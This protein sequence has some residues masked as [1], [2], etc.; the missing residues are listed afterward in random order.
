M[1]KQTLIAFWKYDS[2]PFLL[3]GEVEEVKTRGLVSVKKYGSLFRPTI[4]LPENEGKAFIETLE[5]LTNDYVAEI[6]AVKTKFRDKLI[7]KAGGY[8][9]NLYCLAENK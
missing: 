8:G 7:N 5:E 3:H 6:Q 4:I 9:L 2:F 1:K